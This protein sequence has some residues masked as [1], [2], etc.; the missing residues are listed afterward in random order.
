MKEGGV[1][2]HINHFLATA[3]DQLLGFG[4]HMQRNQFISL[5]TALQQLLRSTIG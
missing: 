4:L 3:L 2:S 5:A 1:Q